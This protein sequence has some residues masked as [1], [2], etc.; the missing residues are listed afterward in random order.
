MQTSQCR[1]AAGAYNF[2]AS[3]S[4]GEPA[5]A[6]K[7]R[8]AGAIIATASPAGLT[9]P[10]HA[11][12][13]PQGQARANPLAGAPTTATNVTDEVI[14]SVDLAKEIGVDA[15]DLR[16]RRLVLEPKQRPSGDGPSGER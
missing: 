3:R 5:R 2:K 9:A 1:C 11:G 13:C 10:A 12:S 6:P 8:L 4:A 15:R 7:T 14:G 16:L